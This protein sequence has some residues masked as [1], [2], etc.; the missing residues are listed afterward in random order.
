MKFDAS[1]PNSHQFSHV[2][3]QGPDTDL[4]W[5]G[6]SEEMPLAE[7]REPFEGDHW[8]YPQRTMFRMEARFGGEFRE[9]GDP[10]DERLSERFGW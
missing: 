9:F 5:W 7:I 4:Q 2:Q 3:V 8:W 10:R 1:E 6:G